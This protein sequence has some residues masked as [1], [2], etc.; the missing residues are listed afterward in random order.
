MMVIPEQQD[1]SSPNLSSSVQPQSVSSDDQF[2]S[3]GVV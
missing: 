2:L 3:E 1:A